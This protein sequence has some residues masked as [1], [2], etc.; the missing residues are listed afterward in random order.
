MTLRCP[1]CRTRRKDKLSLF[2]HL[3]ASQHKT[4]DC[5]GYHFPHRPGAPCC[6]QARYPTMNRARRA[7]APPEDVLEAF[8][9]DALFGQHKPLTQKEA[10]R[11][12]F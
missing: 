3:V 8:L 2:R 9:D 11:I 7:G 4:C 6:E 1:E 12:P 10:E 5:A